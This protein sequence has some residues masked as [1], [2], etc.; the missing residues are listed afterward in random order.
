L[1]A[2][3]CAIAGVARA[4]VAGSFEALCVGRLDS[5]TVRWL[6]PRRVAADYTTASAQT[7]VTMLSILFGDG[8]PK[9]WAGLGVESRRMKTFTLGWACMF[10]R[11]PLANTLAGTV[12]A[13][14]GA[15]IAVLLLLMAPRFLTGSVEPSPTEC[16]KE[17][18]RLCDFEVL[19]QQAVLDEL[20]KNEAVEFRNFGPPTWDGACVLVPWTERTNI[21]CTTAVDCPDAIRRLIEDNQN[22]ILDDTLWGIAFL[23]GCSVQQ[24]S[25]F[26]LGTIN[27]H[28]GG[29]DYLVRMPQQQPRLMLVKRT[30]NN[31]I[32]A[33]TSLG[34]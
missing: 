29:N 31:S 5:G 13:I 20:W 15:A 21:Q 18:L 16:S 1:A 11:S 14:G 4:A 8:V 32:D 30:S 2:K 23:S 24:V 25:R 19:G 27:L 12:V 6:F 28:L 33:R 7:K 3:Y 17:S 34:E 9:T 22:W 26:R 10:R